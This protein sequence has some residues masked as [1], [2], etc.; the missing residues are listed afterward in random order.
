MPKVFKKKVSMIELFY[1]LVFAYMISKATELIHHLHHGMISPISF[2]IF[3][4]VVIIFINS[5]MI[6]TVFT[7]RY[8]KSSWTDIVFYFTGMMI[9]LYMS[10]TFSSANITNLRKLFL[11]AALLSFTL[12]LQ[13]LVVWFKSSNKIDKKIA[14][15]FTVIL[16]IR[17]FFLVMGGLINGMTGFIVAIIGVLLGWILPSFT[18]V[19]T[20]KHPII[21]SHLLERLTLLIIIT[22]GETIIGISD[23]FQEN[24]FSIYSIII[25]VIVATLFFTY[26]TEL[27]HLINEYQDQQTGNLLIYLHYFILFGLSLITVSLKFI[28][29]PTNLLTAASGLYLGLTLFYI[30]VLI[31]NYYNPTTF[32]I[33]FKNIFLIFCILAIGF[34]ISLLFNNFAT[35][36]IT[37]AIVTTLI[38]AIYVHILIKNN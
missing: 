36:A 19:Y 8:G 13:Y 21:F 31:A 14:T 4:V 28:S 22:F 23:Y 38:A 11:A 34:I 37:T 33:Y 12:A 25:F 26:I 10:N 29:E 16:L 17:T 27:D 1:D 5:W 3:A 15:F 2:L 7:N 30:G 9:L 35:I 6:Q 24:T 32:K 20:K 18:G